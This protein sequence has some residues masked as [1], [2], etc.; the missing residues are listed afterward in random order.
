MTV[1]A[2][3]EAARAAA[4]HLMTDRCTVE[5]TD[6]GER[7]WD[8]AN[9]QWVTTPAVVY[10]GPCRVQSRNTQ[11]ANPESAG[12]AATVTDYVVTVPIAATGA[13]LGHAVRIT[14]AAHDP[15][16]PGQLLR[17]TAVQAKSH[18]TA[19]RLICEVTE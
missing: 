3:L 2:A 19:R 8:E 5:D 18:A 7:T 14:A 4:V 17:I 11:P 16:L 10:D 6:A 13:D 1:A 12:W 15:A 9:G